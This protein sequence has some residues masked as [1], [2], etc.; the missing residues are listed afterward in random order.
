MKIIDAAKIRQIPPL[1]R[2]RILKIFALL[3]LF[4]LLCEVG[5]IVGIIALKQSLNTLSD[6]FALTV[7]SIS[8]VICVLLWLKF[9]LAFRKIAYLE[10]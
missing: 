5:Y 8:I 1:K 2:R 3:I 6:I 9:W 10:K 4:N 7:S